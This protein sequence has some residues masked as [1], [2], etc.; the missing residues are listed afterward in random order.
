MQCNTLQNLDTY[1]VT[2]CWR[3]CEF[4]KVQG[5]WIHHFPDASEEGYPYDGKVGKVLKER[6]EY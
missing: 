5:F 1:E 4:G 6:I 3:P 2:R